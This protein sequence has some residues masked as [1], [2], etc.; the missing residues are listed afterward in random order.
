M[1]IAKQVYELVNLPGVSIT[2]DLLEL[3][4]RGRLTESALKSA[5][6]LNDFG[7]KGACHQFHQLTILAIQGATSDVEINGK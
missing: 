7:E 6:A 2:T 4:L 1:W 3:F 5:V